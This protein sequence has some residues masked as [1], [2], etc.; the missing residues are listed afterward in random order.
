[1]KTRDDQCVAC[2]RRKVWGA[3]EILLMMG[4]SRET[5]TMRQP[6][7]PIGRR[8]RPPWRNNGACMRSST[9]THWHLLSP[10][11]SGPR[12]VA[13]AEPLSGRKGD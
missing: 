9:R 1:M 2:G 6:L 7:S 3:E 5:P 13:L 4:P 12:R 11:R 8:P 10:E